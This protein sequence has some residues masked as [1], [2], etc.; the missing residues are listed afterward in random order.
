MRTYL[1]TDIDICV[2]TLFAQYAH[3]DIHNTH[4]LHIDLTIDGQMCCSLHTPVCFRDVCANRSAHG[5]AH[6]NAFVCADLE[7]HCGTL[8]AALIAA[9][10]LADFGSV[11]CAD[12]GPHRAADVQLPLNRSSHYRRVLSGD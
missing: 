2:Q 5:T 9:H 7:S 12:C 10:L 8:L 1:H 4:I 6:S 3:H 11:S